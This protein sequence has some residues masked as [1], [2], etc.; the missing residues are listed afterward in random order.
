MPLLPKYQFDEAAYRDENLLSPLFSGANT[1]LLEAV[2]QHLHVFSTNHGMSKSALTD[3]LKTEKR[4]LPQP[5][6]LPASY[7]EA[8]DLIKH[9]LIPLYKYDVCVNDC[10]VYRDNTEFAGLQSCPKCKEP[11]Y[12]NG[13]V[14]KSFTYMPLGPRLARWFGTFNL[15]K[16]LYAEKISVRG[17][18]TDFVDGSLYNSWF[19]TGG[20]FE[21]TEEPLCVPLS[22]FTDGV[23]PNK[24]TSSQKS[25]WPLILTWI[26]L[27][28]TIRQVMGPM[29]L[30][31]IIPSG[32]KGCEPKTLEPYLE[33]LIEEL[34]DL[35]EFPLQN[36]YIGAPTTVKV[37]LLQFLCD[38]PAYSKLLHLSGH[39]ALRSCPYCNEVGHYCHSLKKTIHVSNRHFLPIGDKMREGTGFALQDRETKNPMTIS[40]EQ[41]KQMR[42][43][44]DSLPNKTQKQKHQKETGLKGTYALMK[45]PYHNRLHQ[46]QPD[47]MHTIADFISHVMDMLIGKHDGVNVRSC[48]K[49]FNRFPEIWVQQNSAVTEALPPQGTK[50]NKKRRLN[51]ENVNPEESIV[52]H[53]TPWSLSKEQIK[54]AD[55]RAASI[56]YSI[57]HNISPGPHFSKP[58]TLRTMNA[59]LQASFFEDSF[60]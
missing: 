11:R 13:K 47:G 38:I 3:V 12:F 37:A 18:L 8:K 30:M 34:L 14:R 43:K 46:M 22:L 42:L 5:N 53:P 58:W 41:E 6:N 36:A 4:T 24:H 44:Y 23:N 27:P 25:M 2:T 7:K 19:Q 59:K 29:L 32:P 15:C 60:N 26:N 16:L 48:E 1:T 10:V 20:V 49:S 28:R 21:A 57:A 40:N 51:E 45:L 35:T 55:A 9:L 50:R 54:T 17:T 52:L 39:S 56:T 33:I 31:G